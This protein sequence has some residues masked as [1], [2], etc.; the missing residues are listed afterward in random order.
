MSE[1]GHFRT[2]DDATAKS[3][4]L[5]KGDISQIGPHVRF[6]PILLQKSVHWMA[7]R[8]SFG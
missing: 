6:V 1:M 8:Q 7:A 4:L 2:S 5:L 3:A